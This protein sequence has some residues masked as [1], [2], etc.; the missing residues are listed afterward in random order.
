[1]CGSSSSGNY[2]MTKAN[3]ESAI[4]RQSNTLTASCTSCSLKITDDSLHTLHQ[5][6][7]RKAFKQRVGG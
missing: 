4:S 1:M 6:I 7:D 3:D 5:T 2:F